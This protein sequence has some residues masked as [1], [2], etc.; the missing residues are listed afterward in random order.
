MEV[1]KMANK[2]LQAYLDERLYQKI[3][4]KAKSEYRSVSKTATM[5]LEQY[6]KTQ[7]KLDA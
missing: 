1:F 2:T 3:E 7:D 6:F 5:I 4:R